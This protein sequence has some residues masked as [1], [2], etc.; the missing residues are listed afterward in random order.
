MN[1]QMK[2]IL[3]ISILCCSCICWIQLLYLSG[4]FVGVVLRYMP[5][6]ALPVPIRFAK[7]F[8]NEINFTDIYSLLQLY[9]LDQAALP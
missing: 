2:L 9:L 3:L 6:S 1:L 7:Q 4:H 8:T 5:T